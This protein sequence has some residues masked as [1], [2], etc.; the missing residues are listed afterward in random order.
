MAGRLGKLMT[1]ELI[2]NRSINTL[3]HYHFAS[4]AFDICL[5]NPYIRK[6]EVSEFGNTL[7]TISGSSKDA[8]SWEVVY[9]K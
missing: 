4:A 8:G 9:A 7:E 5:A 6:V 1:T 2:N 3:K